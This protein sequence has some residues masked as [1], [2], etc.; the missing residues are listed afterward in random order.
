[1]YDKFQARAVVA[2]YHWIGDPYKQ[3]GLV[4]SNPFLTQQTF[5]IT[6]EMSNTFTADVARAIGTAGVGLAAGK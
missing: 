2:A 1:M 3:S 4:I 6:F 5:V